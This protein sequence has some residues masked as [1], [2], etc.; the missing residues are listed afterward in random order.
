MIQRA[1]EKQAEIRAY[2]LSLD[3]GSASTQL[4]RQDH[5]TTDDWRLLNDIQHVLEPI[6]SLTMRTQGHTHGGIHGHSW[7]LMTGMEFESWNTSKSG[8]PSM[9]T[10]LRN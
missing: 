4:P 1:C 9:T 6:Y 2:L 7:E 3:L 5:L 8:K 10:L